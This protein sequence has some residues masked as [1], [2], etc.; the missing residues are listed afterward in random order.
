MNQLSP[1]LRMSVGMLPGCWVISS[2]PRSYLRPSLTQAMY[3]SAAGGCA[4][5]DG[6]RL[7]DDRYRGYGLGVPGRKLLLVAVEDLAQYETAQDQRLSAPHSRD[8]DHAQL[9]FRE[10]AKQLIHELAALVVDT[11]DD[12]RHVRAGGDGLGLLSFGIQVHD[13]R[14]VIQRQSG[15]PSCLS[16]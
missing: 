4:R 11:A 12:V 5:E 10:G 15:C 13:I 3:G 7:L 2:A 8:V 6:L 16:G 9:P 14:D 1:W